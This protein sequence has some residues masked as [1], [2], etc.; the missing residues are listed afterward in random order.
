MLGWSGKFPDDPK[1]PKFGTSI[2]STAYGA[3][4]DHADAQNLA[5]PPFMRICRE[6]QNWRDLRALSGKFLRQKSCFPESFRFL[7]LCPHHMHLQ[8]YSM[9]K[10]LIP[11]KYSLPEEFL[12][13]QYF[14]KKKLFLETYVFRGFPIMH[15][16][17]Y[18]LQTNIHYK[19]K[20]CKKYI[21]GRKK[22][23]ANNIHCKTIFIARRISWWKS[24]F[25]ATCVNR[26][27]PIICTCKNTEPTHRIALWVQETPHSTK[28]QKSVLIKPDMKYERPDIKFDLSYWSK[29]APS[30]WDWT[31]SIGKSSI[32]FPNNI[33]QN[34]V[35]F[36][37]QCKVIEFAL[38]LYP[39]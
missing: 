2:V 19:K 4:L 26:G 25:L 11:N 1:C 36:S 5:K 24:I 17:N 31:N 6:I 39:Y 18:L 34:W 28:S 22:N 27:F 12:G 20:Y 21:D 30:E 38:K 35:L 37:N 8:N 10:L 16:Q 13:K 23:I 3:Y 15:L 32:E 29:Q 9:Q 33:C 14:L 7:W